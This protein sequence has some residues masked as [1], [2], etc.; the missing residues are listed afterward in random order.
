MIVS[1]EGILIDVNVEQCWKVALPM[2][3]TEEGVS[4]DLNDEQP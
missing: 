1:E 3:V 4:I 2:D